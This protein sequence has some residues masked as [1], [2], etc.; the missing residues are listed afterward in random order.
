MQGCEHTCVPF[1]VWWCV[2]EWSH[3]LHWHCSYGQVGTSLPHVPLLV[4][5]MVCSGVH[6]CPAFSYM[7]HTTSYTTHND[8]VEVRNADNKQEAENGVHV[9]SDTFLIP[10]KWTVSI[11]CTY[12]MHISYMFRCLCTIIRDSTYA[13]SLKNQLL[14]W[15]CYLWVQFCSLY[16]M[17]INK[18]SIKGTTELF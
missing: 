16:V 8:S 4:Y 5:C 14:L 6:I 17:D 11:K 9:T 7:K 10:T 3:C 13:S 2:Q 1:H 15:Y 18:Y 12:L